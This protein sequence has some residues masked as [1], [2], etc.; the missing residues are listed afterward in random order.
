[1]YGMNDCKLPVLGFIGLGSMGSG[2][3]SNLIKAGYPVVVYD[4]VGEKVN[5][6]V[7]E[8]VSAAKDVDHLVKLSDIVLTSL[9]FSHV[10][11]DV[12][13]N[14]L[15]PNARN[16]QVFIDLGTVTVR[17]VR[18]LASL[19]AEKGACLIDAPVSGG[20]NGAQKGNL[21]VFIGGDK[22]IA[23]ACWGIFEVIGDPE[24]VVYCGGSGSGQIVKGVNQLAMGLGAAAY[25]ES[26]AFGVLAGV[27]ADTILKA[28]G[29]K[30][31]WRD[32]FTSIVEKVVNGKGENIGVK[33]GQIPYFLDEA[34]L[35][36]FELPLSRA[37]FKFCENSPCTITE[38]NR[39][40]PSFWDELLKNDKE[41]KNL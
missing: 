17:D 39:L 15:I 4:K 36:G 2:M 28:V 32:F 13:E 23:E 25:L 8:G 3:C 34:D 33:H 5:S 41:G 35:K 31:G 6:F 16:G 21:Y 22:A 18:R 1:M 7:Q 40:S 24:H 30:G 9:P 38:A 20:E 11:V 29:G 27:D 26:I 37:L 10:F 14:N 19:F 12:A